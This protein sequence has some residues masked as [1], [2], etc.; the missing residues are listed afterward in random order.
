MPRIVQSLVQPLKIIPKDLGKNPKPFFNL[1]S[2]YQKIGTLIIIVP[3]SNN[4]F[5][6]K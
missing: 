4:C 1:P 3:R 6:K 5:L 2:E